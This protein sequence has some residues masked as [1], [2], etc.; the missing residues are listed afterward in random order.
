M[1]LT[2]CSDL[3]EP[4]FIGC[5]GLDVQGIAVLD[6]KNLAAHKMVYI[7]HWIVV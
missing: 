4:G 7:G 3:A 1:A 5:N 6:G 2:V